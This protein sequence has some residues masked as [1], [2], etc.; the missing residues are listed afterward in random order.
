MPIPKIVNAVPGKS[1]FFNVSLSS[2]CFGC[3][4][5]GTVKAATILV[6]KYTI[7]NRKKP[8]LQLKTW[9]NSPDRIVPNTKPMGFPALKHPNA[10][11]FLRLGLS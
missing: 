2:V 5:L 3:V 4:S 11:F 9:V 8:A 6:T 7:A 10:L 1:S